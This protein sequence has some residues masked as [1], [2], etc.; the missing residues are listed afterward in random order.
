[1]KTPR[2]KLYYK[3]SEI[4]HITRSGDRGI[5]DEVGISILKG[6]ECVADILIGL[7]GDIFK[8]RVLVTTGGDGNGD[9]DLA[10]HPLKPKWKAVDMTYS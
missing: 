10:I 1:M 4:A 8:P 3:S 5:Y 9:K 7:D 2:V 6:E